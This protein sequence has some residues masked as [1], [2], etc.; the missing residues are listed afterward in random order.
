MV[1]QSQIRV[2]GTI[3]ALGR[4]RALTISLPLSRSPHERREAINA[5]QTASIIASVVILASLIPILFLVQKTGLHLSYLGII[6]TGSV[7]FAVLV[8]LSGAARGMGQPLAA[9]I[10]FTV[11]P[12]AVSGIAFIIA[13]TWLGWGA[14]AAIVASIVGQ[15]T[16]LIYLK[17]VVAKSRLPSSASDRVEQCESRPR[18]NQFGLTQLSVAVSATFSAMY[19]DGLLIII[20]FVSSSASAAAF[21]I[22]IRYIRI[23]RFI[24]VSFLH[25][26]EAALSSLWTQ[27]RLC[28]LQREVRDIAALSF[29]SS[30]PALAGLFLFSHFLLE[31]F[32]KGMSEYGPI[33]QI[34]V[35]GE[36]VNALALMPTSVLLMSGNARP[37]AVIYLS[38]YGSGL[39][40]SIWAAQMYGGSGASWT[41]VATN[42]VLSIAT[43]TVCV[44]LTGIR[45]DITSYSLKWLA[46]R[47]NG[48]K[49]I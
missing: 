44:R 41:F 12:F 9:D 35:I 23:A 30:M 19:P 15:L 32:G 14:T 36:L 45:A 11:L 21:G 42:V 40:V 8:V 18:R 5:A 7:S 13:A 47:L 10:G 1:A 22:A 49:R 37:L 28:E 4:D 20:G 17:R 39:V 6:A 27:G 48:A 34:V 29:L 43:S 25:V 46:H 26:R 31:V 2:I 3:G 38:S 24:P 33:L 16:A